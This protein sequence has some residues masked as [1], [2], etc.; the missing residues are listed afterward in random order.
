MPDAGHW[1]TTAE[2]FSESDPS[3]WV[4][5]LPEG[6]AWRDTGDDA[7][8]QH[9]F[10]PDGRNL[11]TGDSRPDGADK[12]IV[13]DAIAALMTA[14]A[15]RIARAVDTPDAPQGTGAQFWVEFPHADG[16]WCCYPYTTLANA[17][18]H[19]TAI[20]SWMVGDA[21]A[22]R[23][24]WAHITHVQ[25]PASVHAMQEAELRDRAAE[26]GRLLR[27]QWLRLENLATEAAIL[28]PS[29]ETWHLFPGYTPAMAATALRLQRIAGMWWAY[30]NAAGGAATHE[31]QADVML[32]K[33]SPAGAAG[34]AESPEQ[35]ADRAL[36]IKP[37]RGRPYLAQ[38]D[39]VAQAVW[40]RWPHL[41]AVAAQKYA[42][43]AFTRHWAKTD[44]PVSIVA[45]NVL[46]RARHT[47]GG[48]GHQGTFIRF[49]RAVELL[50]EAQDITEDRAADLLREAHRR[51]VLG[52]W[53]GYDEG[54]DVNGPYVCLPQDKGALIAAAYVTR[55]LEGRQ[56][57]PGM[58][59]GVSA[60]DAVDNLI[61]WY[62]NALAPGARA[63]VMGELR[64]AVEAG[65]VSA[66][67]SV[68]GEDGVPGMGEPGRTWVGPPF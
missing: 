56:Q 29:L 16:A 34:V 7:G 42:A 39:D 14:E 66:V 40:K 60:E 55:A 54:R 44:S 30:L 48:D 6:Y 2:P 59:L 41:G 20:Q 28:P 33:V 22:L 8:E 12:N 43:N 10:A 4:G 1:P 21:G 36:F 68:A 9:L 51:G 35:E 13:H 31:R 18:D 52:Y 25:P 57:V 58:E 64:Q 24:P 3:T 65:A 38:E 15:E 23:V 27:W 49:W 46:R 47:Y 37:E 62:R 32:G 50:A 19:L 5:T 61:P 45:A 67:H 11:S 17:E 53:D 63:E 26:Y